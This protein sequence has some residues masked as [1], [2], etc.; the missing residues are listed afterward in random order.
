MFFVVVSL[1]FYDYVHFL[2][3]RKRLI[4]TSFYFIFLLKFFS[5]FS[6]TSFGIG[7]SQIRSCRRFAPFCF[8]WRIAAFGCFS[9]SETSKRRRW[10]TRVICSEEK[11][12]STENCNFVVP[13]FPFSFLL[14][15]TS[16]FVFLY[17]KLPRR[18][19]DCDLLF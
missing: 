7:F 17:V 6:F 5:S 8:R 3:R 4:L 19:S 2:Y 1:P 14:S 18:N 10:S 12:S 9:V 15:F 11:R 13:L 16:L